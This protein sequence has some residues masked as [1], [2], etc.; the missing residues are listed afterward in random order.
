MIKWNR[1]DTSAKMNQLFSPA[2][3]VSQVLWWFYKVWL[4]TARNVS[5]TSYVRKKNEIILEIKLNKSSTDFDKCKII[6]IVV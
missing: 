6:N 1:F 4:L 2:A 5:A 3:L